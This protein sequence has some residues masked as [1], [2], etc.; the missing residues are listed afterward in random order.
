MKWSPEDDVRSDNKNAFLP[1][2]LFSWQNRLPSKPFVLTEQNPRN[3]TSRDEALLNNADFAFDE[4]SMW[5]HVRFE[6]AT[7]KSIDL[8]ASQGLNASVTLINIRGDKTSLIYVQQNQ[9]FFVEYVPAET[10]Y[11]GWK[12]IS[13]IIILI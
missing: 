7:P 10:R 9:D 11:A 8:F 12:L 5:G 2:D 6:I 1:D 3:V 13:Y 4:L